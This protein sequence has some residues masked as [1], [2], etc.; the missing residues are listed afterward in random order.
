[1]KKL[2]ILAAVLS[3]F[4]VFAA[5]RA[6]VVYFSWSDAGNTRNLAGIIAKAANADIAE[7]TPQ[8]AY[9]RKYQDVLRRGRMEI[10]KKTVVPIKKVQ[11]DWRKYDIIFVGSPIWFATYAPPVRTFLQNNGLK[12]KKVY[13]FCTHGRGGPGRFFKDAAA[14]TPDAKVGKGFSCYA[15]RMKKVAPKVQRWVKDAMS[16]SPK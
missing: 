13:F 2:F 11:K 6:L 16:A 14:L 8:Q 1:M 3:V 5:E 4:S 10:T 15:T 9:S 12:G 7:L